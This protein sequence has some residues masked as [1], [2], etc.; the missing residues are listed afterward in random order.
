MSHRWSR[1][2]YYESYASCRSSKCD[3]AHI[4]G[5]CQEIEIKVPQHCNCIYS[6]VTSSTNY[7]SFFNMEEIVNWMFWEPGQIAEV[8]RNKCYNIA[9]PYS[10]YQNLQPD[11]VELDFFWS[12]W[13]SSVLD[14]W[15]KRSR[16]CYRIYIDGLIVQPLETMNLL[17]PR[18]RQSLSCSASRSSCSGPL[19]LSPAALLVSLPLHGPVSP[20][21]WEARGE[22][23]HCSAATRFRVGKPLP[24]AACRLPPAACLLSPVASR[25][26]GVAATRF[27]WCKPSLQS[28]HKGR[29]VSRTRAVWCLQAARGCQQSDGAST[30]P[31]GAYPRCFKE[32]SILA[33][34]HHL[35][36]W[37]HSPPAAILADG[38]CAWPGSRDRR[39]GELLCDAWHLPV[40]RNVSFS[41]QRRTASVIRFGTIGDVQNI[42]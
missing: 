24:P 33:R 17:V 18:Q 42:R 36:G 12:W 41:C 21:A 26:R 20:L 23:L 27:R 10:W 29:G 9:A 34:C 11:L 38:R 39:S 40:G 2:R 35:L 8:L 1:F 3:A 28:V 22:R 5:S 30:T 31:R 19:R 32:R 25:L 16:V 15:W 6:T 14:C 7:C 37:V 4:C 13:T